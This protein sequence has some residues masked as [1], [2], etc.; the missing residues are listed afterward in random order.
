MSQSG[1]KKAPSIGAEALL[2]TGLVVVTVL[3]AL[4]LSGALAW[5]VGLVGA[6]VTVVVLIRGG[7]GAGTS[8]LA[9]AITK[10]TMDGKLARIGDEFGRIAVT[11]NECVDQVNQRWSGVGGAAGEVQETASEIHTRNRDVAKSADTTIARAQAALVS[12]EQVLSSFQAV[13]ESS[14]QMKASIGEIAKNA[15]D[16]ARVATDAVTVADKASAAIT[17]LG[18]SSA[19]IGSVVK[20]ITSIAEQTNLLALNATIEAAGAGDAGKGFAVVAGEVKELANGTARATEDI[21]RRIET[22]QTDT[23]RA[24]EAID[25][26]SGVINQISQYSSTIASAVEE[27]NASTNEIGESVNTASEG[28]EQ[29]IENIRNVAESAKNTGI[30]TGEVRVLAK[31]LESAVE[32]L[33]Q[34]MASLR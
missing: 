30:E 18:T 28:T 13:A 3:G 27:Q 10:A 29:I 16:A 31:K 24:V 22:I 17:A 14:E 5:T 8:A 12:S 26:I 4:T 11:W 21:S 33:S 32:T 20:V 25:E 15:G 9:E 6:A 1:S 34:S 2:P 23:K 7:T 19:E